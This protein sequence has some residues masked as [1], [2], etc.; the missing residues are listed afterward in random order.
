[1]KTPNF[2]PLAYFAAICVCLMLIVVLPFTMVSQKPSYQAQL[3]PYNDGDD[4]NDKTLSPYFFI[5][6]DNPDMDQLPLKETSAEV[7]IAGVIADVKVTQVYMNTGKNPIEAMYVFPAS[8]RAAV[9]DMKM[10]IGDRLMVAKIEEKEEAKKQYETAKNN[11]QSASLLEQERPNVFQMNVANIMPGDTIRV[12]MS[13]TELLI[14]ESAVYEFVY[15]T[16]VGPRYSNKSE[17][18]ATEDDKWVESPYTKEGVDPTYAFNITAKINAGMKIRAISCPTH[19]VKV[20]Y[21]DDNSA[22]VKLKKSD[23]DEGNRDF[24]LQ[25][26]LAD[27]A[28]ESGVLLYK[29]ENNPDENFFVTMIQP[30]ASPE[31]DMVPP[32]DF[33]FI[34][35]VSGSMSGFPIETSKK[36][37][38]DLIGKLRPVDKFNVIMFAGSSTS[39]ADK[40]VPATDDNLKKAIRLID[41]QSGGGGT[42]LIP[43]LTKALALEKSEQF[44]R[45]FVIATDGYVDVEKETFD[46]IKKN[47]GNSNFFTFGIG[48]SVNRYLLEGMAHVG[49]GEPFVVT[50]ESDC[51]KKAEKF[52]KYIQTPVLTDITIDYGGFEAYDVEPFNVPDVLAERPIIIYGK[53][54]GEAKGTITV[55]GTSGNSDFS[56]S[57]DVS[58]IQASS[59]NRAIKYL[60]ARQKIKMLDD[61]NNVASTDDLKKEITQIGL[62]YNLLTKY[63]SFIAIDSLVRNN[64]GKTVAVK[65]PLPLPDGVSN[66]A[67]G[68]TSTASVA[69]KSSSGSGSIINNNVSY[70][71]RISNKSDEDKSEGITITETAAEFTGG[72]SDMKL[73]IEKNLVYPDEAKNAGISGTVYVQFTLDEKGGISDVSVIKSL[74]YGCDEEAIRIVKLMTKLWTPAM[75]N[76]VAISSTQTVI[77]KFK[78]K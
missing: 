52:R 69:Y 44:S 66:Y 60:W 76:N 4:D 40:S 50:K 62:T 9:Y 18:T 38:K 1:M 71:K 2:V 30:P 34:M 72:E 65:Q 23:I 59:N 68:E 45:T 27:K 41:Q 11:G 78:T 8:T 25:Y 15:P 10:T 13:Y 24:I 28:I 43:A 63:T 12:E 67:V 29:G 16:V 5:K 47:L 46:L 20:D 17:A 49:M 56:W 55:K 6:S 31:I 35:D 77:I 70:S 53:W 61:Y 74:G 21:E 32:R 39:F 3:K 54:K 42:E 7:N 33:V 64:T 57:F 73:F 22:I 26:K 37:L 14:P 36:L 48:T 19:Q 51:D 75:E 58:K